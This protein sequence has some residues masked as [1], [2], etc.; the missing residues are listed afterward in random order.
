MRGVFV[1]QRYEQVCIE[2][3]FRHLVVP[4][5]T[6]GRHLADVSVR[7]GMLGFSAMI[8]GE[9]VLALA[10]GAADAMAIAEPGSP[11]GTHIVYRADRCSLPGSG[12]GLRACDEV[13]TISHSHKSSKLEQRG[14][15]NRQNGTA[16]P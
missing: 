13:V 3:G 12:D 14:G 5:R 11:D 1:H 15:R 6:I 16:A 7:H 9:A 8:A 4:V 2:H 10:A